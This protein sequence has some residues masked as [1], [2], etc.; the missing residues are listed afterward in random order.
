MQTF[1]QRIAREVLQKYQSKLDRIAIV[2][3]SRRACVFFQDALLKE[4]KS[5]LWSPAVLPLEDFLTEITG[6]TVLDNVSLA[7][8]LYPIYNERFPEEE[9][10]RFFPWAAML[11]RDFDEIDRN[12]I[13]AKSIFT[14]LADLKEIDATIE[15]WLKDDEDPSEFASQYLEFWKAMGDF[16][17]ALRKKLEI[18]RKSTSGGALRTAAELLEENPDRLPFEK[19]IFAGFNALTK[20][21][22]TLIRALKKENKAELYWD[23]DTYYVDNRMQEAGKFFRALNNRMHLRA[24]KWIG[25]HFLEGEREINV[26]GVPQR[27]GQAKAAGLLLQRMM[28]E[29]INPNSIAVVLP[30]ESL[31][32]PLL[33]AIPEQI[34]DINVTMG[35][36]L[37]NTPLFSLVDALI[38]LHENA[39]RIRATKN[40]GQV[41]YF[42]DVRVIIRHPYIRSIAA[43]ESNELLRL[44]NKE[45]VIYLSQ[46]Y[47]DQLP[48]D[49]FFKFLFQPWRDIP[50]ITDFFLELYRRLRK[51]I[52]KDADQ[53]EGIPLP[54][55]T[56]ELEYIFQFYTLTRRLKERLDHYE[57]DFDI[58]TFRRLYKEVVHGASLPFSGEPLKGL[59]IMGMLETRCLDFEHLVLLSVNEGV[60]PAAQTIASFI[61]YNIRKGFDLP[62]F[63][64][65]D[66]IY[67]YHFYRLLQR[68]PR[69]HLLHNTEA[70]IM[71]SGEKSRFIAQIKAEMLPKNPL[72]RYKEDTLTFSAERETVEEILIQKS[73][74]ILLTLGAYVENSG[75]SPSALLSYLKCSLQ[76][77]YRYVLRLKEKE[78]AEEQIQ[79]NTFGSVVHTALEELYTPY[80]GKMVTENDIDDLEIRTHRIVE[81][82]FLEITKVRSSDQGKNLLLVKVIQDLVH[83]LL[84]AD[85]SYTPFEVLGLEEPLEVVVE[86]GTRS[87]KVL[88]KGVIDR[89][90]K[91]EGLIR[92][93]DYKTGRIG[94]LGIKDFNELRENTN[95]KEAFQLATYAYLYL[96][97]HPEVKRVAPGIFS[98]RSISSGVQSLKIGPTKETIT[99]LPGLGG[100]QETLYAILE[101]IFNPMVPFEQTED[102]KVCEWCS[103]KTICTRE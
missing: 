10:D 77:Y 56:V 43:K 47:I 64:D 80:V 15:N 28:D 27:V 38:H 101:E 18:Q 25:D 45:N 62:T 75:F 92:I 39:E 31:L 29:G 102:R 94:N 99:G 6:L 51:S 81:K 85:R 24:P 34:R 57:L 36:P 68:S 14:N 66:A 7:F 98:L 1:I 12:Q 60:L 70:G 44:I 55:P 83:N 21:E 35:F 23:L 100:Y 76:F 87:G 19:V 58:K 2:F 74:G 79:A 41:Y 26:L 13:D 9:F 8:E 52:I 33:H 65:Q 95:K 69:V 54:T 63:E 72:I 103:Y 90:D 61:P 96:N 11:V 50:G 40:Y 30:D 71:G 93:V 89:I 59:Q 91:K 32:F 3:P 97:K 46:S 84:E 20:A 67:A 49:N 53:T 16:Y 17:Q 4:A 82:S 73:E 78:E 48:E 37:R 5:A 22:E 86:P 88:L 42:R